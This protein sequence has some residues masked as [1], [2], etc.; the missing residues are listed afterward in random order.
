LITTPPT[1]WRLTSQRNPP[2]EMNPG[3]PPTT[4][5]TLALRATGIV[6]APQPATR[7]VAR[8]NAAVALTIRRADVL[9]RLPVRRIT[10]VGRRCWA[11]G[12]ADARARRRDHVARRRI[13]GGS[14]ATQSPDLDRGAAVHH[15]AQA[16]VRGDPCRLPVDHAELEPQ[17]AR[18]DLDGLAGVRDAELGSAKDIDDIED[19]GRL[20]RLAERPERRHAEDRLLPGVDGHTVVPLVDQVPEDAE[21]RPR[22]V[23][24]RADDGDPAC[25]SE[26]IRDPLAVEEVDLPAALVE[27]EVGD[28]PRP[29][30]GTSRDPLGAVVRLVARAQV[31][32][33]RS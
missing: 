16:G 7:L 19:T 5:E 17:A 4:T 15:D 1:A 32:D 13:D 27:I 3:S 26:Q 20:G 30:G 11:R 23:G 22:L 9:S 33:S 12:F 6:N 29:L 8:T 25:R 14:A 18:P 24:R 2:I 21:R 28:G 10:T 31:A